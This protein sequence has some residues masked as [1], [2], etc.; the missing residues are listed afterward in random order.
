MSNV[1]SVK[2]R[3]RLVY[4]MHGEGEICHGDRCLISITVLLNGDHLSFLLSHNAQIMY[5]I[6]YIMQMQSIL[7]GVLQ[8]FH[9]IRQFSPNMTKTKLMVVVN[10]L[11]LTYLQR[12][13]L[14]F[15]EPQYR[16]NTSVEC[17]FNWTW[18]AYHQF[19]HYCANNHTNGLKIKTTAFGKCI[20][21]CI[22]QAFQKQHWKYETKGNIICQFVGLSSE[23][24]T[25]GAFNFGF[26][27]SIPAGRKT[28]AKER[29]WEDMSSD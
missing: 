13:R 8:N 24:I 28:E 18:V 19:I 15:I 25:G 20:T 27:D 22:L 10:V 26:E 5:V 3:R 6:L 2:W 11:E 29:R 16:S 7:V 23:S 1:W 17:L 21:I 12:K 9:E 14:I 4:N